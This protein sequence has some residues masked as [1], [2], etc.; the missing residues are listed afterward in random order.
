MVMKLTLIYRVVN[1]SKTYPGSHQVSAERTSEAFKPLEPKSQ[2]LIIWKA[3]CEYLKEKVYDYKGVNVKNFGTFT[4][5]VSTQLPK[6]GIDYNQAKMKS[7]GELVIE[8]KTT[9]SLRP[10]F[11]ID[12]RF[13]KLLTRFKDKEELTKPKSQSSVFQRGFQMT[14][15]NPIPIAAACYINSKVVTDGL[16]AIFNALYDLINI[17]KNVELKTGFCNINF[18]DRNLAY[19]FAPDLGKTIKNLSE[20]ENKVNKQIKVLV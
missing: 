14:Y 7:F 5:E 15:C 13:K 9:H 12:N 10:C 18:L 19:S 20:S 17:G 6:T 1:N 3:F 8:K 2:L 16:N 11:V 4:Y